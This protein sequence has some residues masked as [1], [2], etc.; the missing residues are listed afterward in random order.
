[1]VSAQAD[2]REI[3]ARDAG[4]SLRAAHGPHL[5]ACWG[6]TCYRS[7]GVGAVMSGPRRTRGQFIG[8]NGC[9]GAAGLRIEVAD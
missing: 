3:A 9:R 5:A 4:A 8:A 7:Q 6:N 2:S 1:M